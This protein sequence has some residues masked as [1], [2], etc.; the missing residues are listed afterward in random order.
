MSEF[1]D[2]TSASLRITDPFRLRPL[3]FASS[4]APFPR[5]SKRR[6]K[7][8]LQVLRLDLYLDATLL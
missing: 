1:F 4:V 8:L 6:R 2:A 3:P 7:K 5:D